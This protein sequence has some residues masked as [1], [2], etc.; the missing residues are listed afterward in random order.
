MDE[1][2]TDLHAAVLRRDID[3]SRSLLKAGADVNARDKDGWTPLYQACRCLSFE[4]VRFLLDHG[5]DPNICTA[6][7]S[8]PLH[9]ACMN[10]SVDYVRILLQH[11]ADPGSKDRFGETALDKIAYLDQKSS[12]R[13]EILDLFREYAPELILERF[14]TRGP[15]PGGMR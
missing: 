9:A 5:A 4:T 1:H 15:G 8:T 11:G 3:L 6:D 2:Y 7:N 14:C 10:S 13:E 12:V